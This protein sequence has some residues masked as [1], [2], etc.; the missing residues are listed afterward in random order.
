LVDDAVPSGKPG[1]AT[2]MD[3]MADAIAGVAWSGE[4]GTGIARLV[5]GFAEFNGIRRG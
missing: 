1:R 5:S 2:L 4:W 3:Q